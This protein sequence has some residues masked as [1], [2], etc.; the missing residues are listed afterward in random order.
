MLAFV[1]IFL[2]FEVKGLLIGEA[3]SAEVQSGIHEIIEHEKANNGHILAINEIRTMQLG[4]R[5]IL[6]AASVDFDDTSTAADVKDTTQR[7]ES[8]IKAAYPDVRK[9]YIEVQAAADHKAMLETS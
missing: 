3:A 6:V 2:S 7:V 1:A 8:A 9:F 5:D 4:A